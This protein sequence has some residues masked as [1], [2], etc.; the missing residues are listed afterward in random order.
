MWNSNLIMLFTVSTSQWISSPPHPPSYLSSSDLSSTPVKE[1][2]FCR[3]QSPKKCSCQ[4]I[5]R[6][7]TTVL[8]LSP[9]PRIYHGLINY[10]DTKTSS[11]LVFN[12]GYRLEHTVSHDGIFYPALWTIAPLTLF[13]LSFSPPLLP[14]PSQSQSTFFQVNCKKCLVFYKY[15]LN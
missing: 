5:Q 14:P 3:I 13:F 10:K 6:H 9:C 8:H 15:C 11:L 12:R 1:S 2:I 4:W 7:F